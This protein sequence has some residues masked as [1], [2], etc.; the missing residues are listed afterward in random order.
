M[1]IN[2]TQGKFVW[3]REGDALKQARKL[4]PYWKPASTGSNYQGQGLKVKEGWFHKAE[5]DRIRQS[6]ASPL[7][8]KRWRLSFL[9]FL[10]LSCI[11]FSQ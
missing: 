2:L 8:K 7:S 6:T 3:G 1:S 5:T 10:L 4:A 9:S 11:L